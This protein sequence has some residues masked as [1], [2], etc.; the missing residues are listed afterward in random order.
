VKRRNYIVSLAVFPIKF[1]NFGYAYFTE[2]IRSIPYHLQH[3]SI[4][5]ISITES[6]SK[7]Y[8]F[9]NYNTGKCHAQVPHSGVLHL[10]FSFSMWN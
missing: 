6:F 8:I 7:L 2:K 5:Y 9:V 1:Y 3:F 10:I 4:K